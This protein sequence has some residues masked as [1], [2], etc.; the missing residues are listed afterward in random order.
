M[1]EILGR[2]D[3]V[4]L[5]KVNVRLLR[6]VG[7]FKIVISLQPVIRSTLCLVLLQDRIFTGVGVSYGAISSWTDFKQGWGGG[8]HGIFYIYL[9]NGTR[10]D[11][12]YY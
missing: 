12:S 2:L 4:A 11:L 10:Y 6:H 8:K 1:L 5:F 3:I 7:K 9:E